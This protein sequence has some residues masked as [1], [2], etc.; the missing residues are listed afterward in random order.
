[1][2]QYVSVSTKDILSINGDLL[3][4]SKLPNHFIIISTLQIMTLHLMSCHDS[5]C[6]DVVIFTAFI[7]FHIRAACHPFSPHVHSIFTKT[8]VLITGVGPGHLVLPS[9]LQRSHR[10]GGAP[11]SVPGTS[12]SAACENQGQHLNNTSLSSYIH[13]INK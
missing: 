12:P 5:G 11:W 1:M 10:C 4:T 13:T 3:Q 7:S 8:F 2:Y 9:E 6:C